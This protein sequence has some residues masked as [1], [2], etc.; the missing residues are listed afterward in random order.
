MK[1]VLN[2]PAASKKKKI[3]LKF[4]TWAP[5]AGKKQGFVFFSLSGWPVSLYFNLKRL[6]WAGDLSLSLGLGLVFFFSP[7]LFI[8][9]PAPRHGPAYF[10]PPPPAP[11]T[12]CAILPVL[13]FSSFF[14]KK[15][16][17]TPIIYYIFLYL[18]REIKDPARFLPLEGGGK[19][20]TK[21]TPPGFPPPPFLPLQWF[22]GFIVVE[23]IFNKIA[24]L[25]SKKIMVFPLPPAVE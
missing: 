18:L 21:K 23:L 11:L 24:R 9:P 4:Q 17:K 8:L 16:Q 10:P 22:N 2:P 3:K 20:A 15:N 1:Q 5:A 12:P 25:F 7:S 19:P 13:P 14:K 6:V